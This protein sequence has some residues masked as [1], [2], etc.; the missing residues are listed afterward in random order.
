MRHFSWKTLHFLHFLH[1]S[2]KFHFNN[3][4][5]F[6]TNHSTEAKIQSFST[7]KYWL[8]DITI[9][10]W[11]WSHFT[12]NLTF[13]TQFDVEVI[14]RRSAQLL[15]LQTRTA[16]VWFCLSTTLHWTQLDEFY[17]LNS[18]EKLSWNCSLKSRRWKNNPQNYL[19]CFLLWREI[20]VEDGA[21]GDAH[22]DA[23]ED[24]HQTYLNPNFRD[25]ERNNY[26]E[27]IH[28]FYWTVLKE[29]IERK[30]SCCSRKSSEFIFRFLLWIPVGTFPKVTDTMSCTIHGGS[31]HCAPAGDGGKV[32][33]S[34]KCVFYGTVTK[35]ALAEE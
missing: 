27:D 13:C 26:L 4:C 15:H 9:I 29:V 32:G 11:F 6:F 14:R 22:E 25:Q 2:Q 18:C 28:T 17:F 20:K 1:T 8:S 16:S 30:K 24:A 21:S 23:H 10:N 12:F 34:I 3:I 33:V 7:L 5:V 19:C 31:D 35:H